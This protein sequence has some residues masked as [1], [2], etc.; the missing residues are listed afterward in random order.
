M[1]DGWP[2]GLKSPVLFL[3]HQAPANSWSL[4]SHMVSFRPSTRK[5]KNKKS[6]NK[7]KINKN[8]SSILVTHQAHRHSQSVISLYIVRMYALVLVRTDTTIKTNDHLWPLGLVGQHS[9]ALQGLA[10]WITKFARL[11]FVTME[12]LIVLNECVFIRSCYTILDNGIPDCQSTIIS[13]NFR[14]KRDAGSIDSSP[15]Q[16]PERETIK[17][18]KV[19]VHSLKV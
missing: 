14:K 13:I 19:T 5:T 17:A 2:S 7:K 15:I 4:V 1:L 3:I 9:T 18:S 10:W 16:E 6:K 12:N 11:V 8:K